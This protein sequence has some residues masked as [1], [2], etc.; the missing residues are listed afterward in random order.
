MN[1]PTETYTYRCGEKIV[2]RKKADQFVVRALPKKLKTLGLLELEQVSSS[3]TRITTSPKDLESN[4]SMCRGFAATHHAYEHKETGDNFLITDRIFVKFKTAPSNEILNAFVAKY[5]L[6]LREKYTATSFLFKLTDYTGMNPIKLV[7]HLTE[8]DELIDSAGHDLNQTVQKYANLVP[9]DTNYLQQWHLHERLNDDEFDLR[10]SSN[11]EAAWNLLGNYGSSDVVVGVTDDGCLLTHVDFDSPDKFK[12]WGYFEGSRLISKNSIGAN[13]ESMYQNGSNHGTSCAGV[14]AGEVDAV[15][16]V[17]ASPAASLLPIKWESSGPSLFISDSK[18]ITAL[19]FMADKVDV[20]SNSWGVSPIG[21]WE[22]V[23][24]DVIRELSENGGR[25][26]KGIVFLWAAG[27][28]NCP[29]EY[30]SDIDIPYTSGVQFRGDGS[31]VWVGVRTSKVFRHNLVDLPGVMHIAALAS[32]AKRSHYSNY[33]PGISLC[34]ASSNVHTYYRLVLEGLGVTTTTGQNNGEITGVTD[35]FGGTSSATPLV[36]GI[37]ALV[38]A[39]NPA[40]TAAEVISILKKTASKDLN[41]EGYPKTPPSSFD[42]NTSWDVSPVP[43]FESGAFVNID[44]LEGTWSPWFGHGNVN[45][46]EAVKE[47]LARLSEDSAN[48]F[49][50]TSTPSVDIPDNDGTGILEKLECT[51]EGMLNDIKVKV[52]I[53]HTYI[54]DLLISLVA[55]SG[56][57]VLLHNRNGG[58]TNDLKTTF[59]FSN[60][61][62]LVSLLGEPIK[63]DWA[64]K[65]KDMAMIDMGKLN[66]WEMEIGLIEGKEVL[67]EKDEGLNIPDDS[68]AGVES[69]LSVVEEG[70][71]GDVEIFVDLTH[72]YIGDLTLELISP[73]GESFMLH[74]RLG[75]SNDNIIKSYSMLDTSILA[76]LRG[77][78]ISGD[79]KLKVIDHVIADRGK[80]NY[81]RIKFLL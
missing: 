47:A 77:K 59:D 75:G 63:G 52:D 37:A 43:P 1:N 10:A 81:W 5:A 8:E 19:N 15:T 30:T 11:C 4:M 49:V 51:Q 54:G 6:I 62:T 57:E 42:S 17:G 35:F 68:A 80:L 67:V 78:S 26:G 56:K 21:V 39:A 2:L 61:S 55:P 3:S 36:A 73:Q 60:T 38:I 31:L 16:T 13:P 72:T 50:A 34:A 76:S 18:L 29:I 25:R 46:L 27:N 14:V 65:V 79:W 20:V 71:I 69:T 22:E 28:E 58:T 12:D 44:A 32:T 74:N 33:G 45:A 41:F 40:L 64:L 48:V 7:V 53:S 70:I 23:V 9:T 66:S 24:L